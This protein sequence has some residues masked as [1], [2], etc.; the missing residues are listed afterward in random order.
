MKF[1]RRSFRRPVSAPKQFESFVTGRGGGSVATCTGDRN[2]LDNIH[3]ISGLLDFASTLL[4]RPRNQT[5]PPTPIAHGPKRS[6]VLTTQRFDC[7]DG[8]VTR[9][10]P[11]VCLSLPPCVPANAT[12]ILKVV[13]GHKGPF[14]YKLASDF[15]DPVDNRVSQTAFGS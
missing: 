11:P 6:P 14:R 10:R 15:T 9:L 3:Y 12:R 5:S 7:R 13:N 8:A 2:T 4:I 1:R